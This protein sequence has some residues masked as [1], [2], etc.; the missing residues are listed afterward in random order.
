M[1]PTSELLLYEAARTQHVKEVIKPFLKK[2][3]LSS[4]TVSVMPPSPIKVMEEE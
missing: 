4:A 2:G 3:G 1:V